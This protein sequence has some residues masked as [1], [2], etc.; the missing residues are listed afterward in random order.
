MSSVNKKITVIVIIAVIIIAAI[1]LSWYFI[2]KKVESYPLLTDN[3]GNLRLGS[4]GE[5]VKRLQQYLNSQLKLQIWKERPA[6][7][8]KEINSLAEDGI[9]GEQT[10][11]V[12]RWHFNAD[13]V[14]VERLDTLTK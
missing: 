7:K 6:Y 9:F 14:A 10:L 4:R 2:R 1:A 3:N 12:V 13:C 11:A 5:D 8:G